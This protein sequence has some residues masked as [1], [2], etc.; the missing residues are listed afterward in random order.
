MTDLDRT[1]SGDAVTEALAAFAIE[2]DAASIPARVYAAARIALLDALG[3]AFAGW[4]AE[5]VHAAAA[6]ALEQG[7]AAQ[8]TLWFRDRKIPAPTA[9][10][11]N[12]VQLHALDFDDYHPPSD[13]HITSVLVPVVLATAE[14]TDASGRETLAAL[15]LGADVVGRLGRAC[16][17]RREQQGFLPTSLI[18]G[19][20]AAAA[21]CRLRG[22]SVRQ[23][24]D[25]FGIFYAHA[26]GNRQ[27]LYDR[28]LTKRMQPGIA[29]RAGLTACLLAEKGVSGPRRIFGRQP[30]SL[31]RLYGF[32]AGGENSPLTVE[33]ITQAH[34]RWTLEELEYKRFACCGVSSPAVDT[35]ISLAQEHDLTAEQVEVIRVFDCRTQSPLGSARWTDHPTPQVLAQFCIAYAVASALENRRFGPGEIAP[36]RIAEDRVVDELAR[37]VELHDRDDWPDDMA[38]HASA[39]ELQLKDGRVVKKL[40]KSFRRFQSPEDDASIITKCRENLI[41]SGRVDDT[42][43]EQ[44]L[45]AVQCLDQSPAIRPLIREFLASE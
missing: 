10:F 45:D 18:G 6:L 36:N 20:G 31:P 35:V 32:N 2:T 43:A 5:G 26:S 25:A 40:N 38:P 17:K 12:A 4:D 22:C 8:A 15:I 33:E 34:D 27:A 16:R 37:G 44:F 13:A 41:F 11:A 23:T 24:V 1:E 3:C 9:A 14:E 21:A 28:T 7:G 29:A 42:G 30:A 19:F 39:V